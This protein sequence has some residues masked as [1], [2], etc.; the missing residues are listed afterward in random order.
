[1][2]HELSY[3]AN[4]VAEMAYVGETPWHREGID[5]RK[6]EVELGRKLSYEEWLQAGGLDFEVVKRP[7]LIEL[8]TPDGDTYTKQS[9][10]AYTTW[11]TD[12]EL[13]LGSVG[14]V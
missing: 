4:G 8:R 11:R 2:A 13:E 12:R 7:C 9:E 14:S 6:R 10:H 3:D 1:M 5:I